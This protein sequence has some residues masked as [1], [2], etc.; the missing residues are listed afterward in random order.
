[1]LKW[2]EAERETHKKLEMRRKHEEAQRSKMS[3]LSNKDVSQVLEAL[4]ELI[5]MFLLTDKEYEIL[6]RHLTTVNPLLLL[7]QILPPLDKINR[8][9]RTLQQ[10]N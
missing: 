2:Q 4:Q 8:C 7:L 9:K 1:M 5:K 6:V 10:K 3:G